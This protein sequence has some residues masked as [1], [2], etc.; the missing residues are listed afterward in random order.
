MNKLRLKGDN[1]T[2]DESAYNKRLK[3]A[4]ELGSESAR[5]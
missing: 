5:G 4:D 1:I 2:A 3:A